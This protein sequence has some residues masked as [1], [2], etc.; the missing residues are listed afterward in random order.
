MNKEKEIIRSISNF[1]NS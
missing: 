1:G